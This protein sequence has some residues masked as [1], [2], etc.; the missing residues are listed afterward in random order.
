MERKIN[1][2]AAVTVLREDGRNFRFVLVPPIEANINEGRL[3]VA[4]PLGKALL[5]R[6]PGEEFTFEAPGGRVKMT[7]LDVR[8]AAD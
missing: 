1:P 8:P 2:G 7:V 3:S 6:E 5:G 4:A